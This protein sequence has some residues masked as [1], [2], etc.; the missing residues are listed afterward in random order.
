MKNIIDLQIACDDENL[1]T[2]SDIQNWID[3]TLAQFNSIAS[4]PFSNAQE[5][6]VRIV[7]ACESQ[8]L[9]LNY[10][11]KDKATNVLSFPFES[12]PEVTLDLLGDLLICAEVVEQEA[13]QQN[14]QLLH[15][16]AHMIVHGTLHLLGYDHIED[17]DA[18]QMEALEISILAKLAIDDPYQDN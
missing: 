1:P 17:D 12:P 4:E 16:W 11:G 2:E 15:H 6:T 3:T 18:Q 5:I 10:R 8:Q 14:K 13:Q 9:N 7:D